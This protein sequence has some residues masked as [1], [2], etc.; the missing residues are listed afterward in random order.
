[1]NFNFTFHWVTAV[2]E[3]GRDCISQSL[4]AGYSQLHREFVHVH[5]NVG[6]GGNFPVFGSFRGPHGREVAGQGFR[7]RHGNVVTGRASGLPRSGNEVR[8]RGQ[9]TRSDRVREKST[10]GKTHPAQVENPVLGRR[11]FPSEG[12]AQKVTNGGNHVVD[13]HHRSIFVHEVVRG[14]GSQQSVFDELQEGGRGS[15]AAS[16]LERGWRS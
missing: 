11:R 12:L 2:V 16:V 8:K 14:N 3:N 13:V 10:R 5:G 9:E 6:R 1:M 7:H 4:R 15:L